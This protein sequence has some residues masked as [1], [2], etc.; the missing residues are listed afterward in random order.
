MMMEDI[1]QQDKAIE[2]RPPRGD[3][4]V[5]AALRVWRNLT[6]GEQENVFAGAA[7]HVLAYCRTRDTDHL[8]SFAER[9]DEMVRLE[10][11][12]GFTEARRRPPRPNP[13]PVGIRE[14]IR[15]LRAA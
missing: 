3:E 11:A 5:A 2:A 10:Q 8:V 15:R 9:V 12:P 13:A 6:V 14:V 7:Q 1:G 4:D